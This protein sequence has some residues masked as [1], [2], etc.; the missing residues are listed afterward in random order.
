M[1]SIQKLADYDHPV[2][3]E[4]ADRLTRGEASPRGK[5]EKLFYFVRDE[6]RFG[7]PQDGDLVKASETIGLGMGQCNTKG[8]LFLALC[9][10][11]GIPARIHF[12]LIK[13][14]IQR[15]LFTGIGYMLMPSLLSHSWVE[16][17]IEG[18]WRRLD[19]YIN[20]KPF[21]MAGKKALRERGWGTGYSISCA[22]GESSADF[23]IDDEKFVQMDAVAADHGVWDDP[24]D[25]YR[26]DNY[27]NRPN[28]IKRLLYRL[29]ISRVNARVSRMRSRSCMEHLDSNSRE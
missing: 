27:R 13:K 16:V 3:R 18:K 24:S 5:L 7:F 10:A 4:T 2:V 25:Y 1:K 14:E 11:A 12:S 6:I 19:S 28:P 15:G 9:R 21:Y 17:R 29:L 8:A 23:Q 20:D 22:S 26:S